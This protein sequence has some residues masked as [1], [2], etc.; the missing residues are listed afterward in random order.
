MGLFLPVLRYVVGN[1]HVNSIGFVFPPLFLDAAR[2]TDLYPIL[3]G[4]AP[5]SVE[6]PQESKLCASVSAVRSRCLPLRLPSG[7]LIAFPDGLPGL[8][9]GTRTPKSV[10]G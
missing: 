6:I 5:S 3:A 2:K 7:A 4:L 1:T 9:D 10:C 8:R